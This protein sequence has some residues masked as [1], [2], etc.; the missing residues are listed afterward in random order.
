MVRELMVP[1]TAWCC[2]SG[3]D[4]SGATG[5]YPK[6]LPHCCWPMN[7]LDLRRIIRWNFQVCLMLS[8]S[9]VAIHSPNSKM[10]QAQP[11]EWPASMTRPAG[12]APPFAEGTRQV[13]ARKLSSNVPTFFPRSLSGTLRPYPHVNSAILHIALVRRELWKS[14]Q[15]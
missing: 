13:E 1:S 8:G 7:E 9:K 5:M 2:D 10:P 11:D 4:N 6:A 15:K 14:E 12:L 3:S